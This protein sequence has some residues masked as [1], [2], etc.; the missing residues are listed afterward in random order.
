MYSDWMDR[1]AEADAW[2]RDRARARVSRWSAGPSGIVQAWRR[3]IL[4]VPAAMAGTVHR[5]W[6]IGTLEEASEIL[7]VAAT[8]RSY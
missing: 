5:S 4:L 6:I 3:E 2:A 7:V 1:V 8:T